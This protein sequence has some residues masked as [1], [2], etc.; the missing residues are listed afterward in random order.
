MRVYRL[1]P[2]R[3][4]MDDPRL[5]VTELKEGC[6]VLADSEDDARRQVELATMVMVSLKEGEPVLYSPWLDH[7]LTE[8]A[9]SQAPVEMRE[10][11]I[12]SEG[13]H[14]YS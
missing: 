13:G 4:R 8:C 11:I 12:V 2:V 3:D 14:T 5:D 7:E 9:P 10:G 1:E 6:W